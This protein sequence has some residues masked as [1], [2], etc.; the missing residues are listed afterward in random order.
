MANTNYIQ[1]PLKNILNVTRIVTIF[2]RD[3]PCGFHNRGETHDFWEIVYVAKGNMTVH[4][5]DTVQTLHQG[6][7]IFHAPNEF[8]NI[9]SVG[10]DGASFWIVTF[11]STSA[12]MNFFS[13]KILAP[14]EELVRL[15]IKL[16]DEGTHTFV[17][18]EYP[19]VTRDDAPIGGQ[20]LIRL[21]LETFLLLMIRNEESASQSKNI[22]TSRETLQN[23]LAKDIGLY[24]SEHLYE[25]ITLDQIAEHFH[26]GK[27]YLCSVFKESMQNTIVNYYL[28][29][30]ISE[31]KKLLAN[32]ALSIREIS[33]KLSFETP[34]YFSRCFKK[35]T[36]ISPQKFRNT[37]DSFS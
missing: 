2:C 10:D 33:E 17:G 9:E 37:L 29:L 6:E 1:L 24:L 16:I 36:G 15:F 35:H 31:A 20:Q 32:Q 23:T 26:F 27:S 34:E 21:Y 22:F 14:S 7:M 18:L 13:Q 12:V 4:A 28:E 30:K 25:R 8:H 3:V 11:D 19:L 5:D